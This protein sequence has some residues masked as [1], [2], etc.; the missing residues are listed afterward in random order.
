MARLR[1]NRPVKIFESVA[2]IGGMSPE[3]LRQ[4]EASTLQPK[5]EAASPALAC[6]AMGKAKAGKAG[7]AA[8]AC[9]EVMFRQRPQPQSLLPAGVWASGGKS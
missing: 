8:K 9:A 3:N 1:P 5:A 2:D 6:G 4:C 7:K